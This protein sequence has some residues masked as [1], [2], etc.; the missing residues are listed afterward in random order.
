MTAPDQLAETLKKV[1]A[2]RG[3]PHG[4]LSAVYLSLPAKSLYS[5][6]KYQGERAMDRSVARINIEHFRRLLAKETDE[7]RRQILLRLLAEEEAKIAE[8]KPK[9]RKRH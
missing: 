5:A 1:L 4:T 6:R 9:E 2:R 3:R 7:A 8:A